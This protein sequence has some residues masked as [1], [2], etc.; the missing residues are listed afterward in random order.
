MRQTAWPHELE[1]CRQCMTGGG[2]DR[3][4]GSRRSAGRRPDVGDRYGGRGFRSAGRR[5]KRFCQVA[6]SIS[7]AR[8]QG[9]LRRGG[10]ESHRLVQGGIAIS[11]RAFQRPVWATAPSWCALR[12][13]HH[14]SA[15]IETPNCTRQSDSHVRSHDHRTSASGQRRPCA[16][17]RQVP[18]VR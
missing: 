6:A 1:P 4:S 2:D 10:E 15:T 9:R 13:L 16:S 11:I 12:L 8:Q 7:Y 14:L 5:G 18:A 3:D 17:I